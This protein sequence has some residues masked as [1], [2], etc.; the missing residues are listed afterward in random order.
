[1]KIEEIREKIRKKELKMTDYAYWRCRQRKIKFKDV[2]HSI[3]SGEIIEEYKKAH[4]HK[5]L[6]YGERF[7]GD[8]LHIVVIIAPVL[9]I[10]TVYFPDEERW[11]KGKVR[12]R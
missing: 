1:L 2:I 12:R 11:I 8:P 6:I 4:I 9:K 10:K 5:C 7:N 3:L